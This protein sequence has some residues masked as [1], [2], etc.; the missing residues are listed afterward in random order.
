MFQSVSRVILLSFFFAFFPTLTY[1]ITIESGDFVDEIERL[2]DLSFEK[3][4]NL[5]VAPNGSERSDFFTLASSLFS[6]NLVTADTQ[7]NALNYELVQFTDTVTNDVYHGLREQLVNNQQTRGWGSFFVNLSYVSDV[8]VEIPHPRFD[9][10]TWDV[11]AKVFRQAEARGILMAGAHR[12]TNG[13]GTADV[14]HLSDSIFHE[15]HKAWNG[16]NAQTTAWQIHGFDGDNH[17]FPTGT[18]VVLSSGDGGVSSNVITLDGLFDS[19][20]DSGSTLLLSHAYNA[21]ADNDPLNVLV[22]GIES[23]STFSSLGGTTNVQGIYSRGLGGQFVHVELEQ[24]IRFN[25][26]NRD[27]AADVIAQAMMT[28]PEP[29]TLALLVIGC[30][31]ICFFAIRG[32]SMVYL[33]MLVNRHI[34]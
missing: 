26:D 12:N 20:L 6:G 23:G 31:G 15:V 17:S 14:A 10:N 1:G 29:G 5:Y 32:R 19:T 24:S 30:I 18:D 16:L 2:R 25:A 21:L 4:T 8:L 28:V 33:K 11:G 34:G 22:N 3:N 27:I 9:T 13:Q 7:A